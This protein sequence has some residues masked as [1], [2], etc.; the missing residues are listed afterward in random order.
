MHSLLY[1]L[2]F[3]FIIFILLHAQP[4]F[5]ESFH[6][7]VS[8]C[9]KG[10]LWFESQV[11]THQIF[12][13]LLIFRHVDLCRYNSEFALKSSHFFL[14]ILIVLSIFGVYPRFSLFLLDNVFLE[15]FSDP[16]L[17]NS[18]PLNSKNIIKNFCLWKLLV[19][20]PIDSFIVIFEHLSQEHLDDIL[21][22]LFG[23]ENELSFHIT[24]SLNI[25]DLQFFEDPYFIF[26]LLFEGGLQTTLLCLCIHNFI[27]NILAIDQSISTCFATALAL[28]ISCLKCCKEYYKIV[29]DKSDEIVLNNWNVSSS[30][31]FPS[32]SQSYLSSFRVCRNI[33]PI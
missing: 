12:A 9:Q 30:L 16:L 20:C 22:E 19:P 17:L 23:I 32:L 8:V 15:I 5:I 29:I 4:L 31:L 7:T 13:L 14:G 28:N 1:W 10:K 3:F 33:D 25:F 2:Y 6:T 11:F 27:I 21:L 26:Q 24:D 18:L